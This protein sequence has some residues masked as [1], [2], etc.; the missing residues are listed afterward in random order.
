MQK[1]SALS[2]EFVRR[3]CTRLEQDNR[4]RRNLPPWGRLHIDRQLPFLCVYRRPPK[5]KDAGTERLLLGE[6]S[7]LLASGKPSLHT[8]N[9]RSRHGAEL[10]ESLRLQ[11]PAVRRGQ[12]CRLDHACAPNASPRA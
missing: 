3:V 10:P 2:E 9:P 7:Y 11:A 1:P 5:S 12:T 8:H 4:V 6:A